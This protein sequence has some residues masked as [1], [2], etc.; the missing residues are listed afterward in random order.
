MGVLSAHICMPTCAQCLRR[1]EEGK[2]HL[3]IGD[4]GSWEL[5]C[6]M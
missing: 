1:P 5:L 6:A 2:I 3:V 4:T